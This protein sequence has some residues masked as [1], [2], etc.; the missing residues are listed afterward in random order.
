[1]LADLPHNEQALVAEPLP[2]GLTRYTGFLVA[3]ANQRL[4]MLFSERTRKLGM[5]IPCVGI[6]HLLDESGPTTQQQIGR[7]LRIDRTSMV[8]MLDILEK[9]KLARRKDHP[10]DRRVYIIE[11]TAAGRKM[12]A[13]LQKIA[14]EMEKKLL[15][16][17][18]ATERK[19]IRRALL[20][21]AG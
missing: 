8:K 18:S 1:M 9:Q 20:T 17:F 14:D 4:W 5:E 6:L 3:K 15:A 16:E 13:A 21:L 7:S 2:P 10:D 11:I 12:L 19:L